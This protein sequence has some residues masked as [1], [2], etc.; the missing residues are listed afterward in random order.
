MRLSVP[1]KVTAWNIE[2]MKNLVVGSVILA[3]QVML[4]PGRALE[5]GTAVGDQ[6]SAS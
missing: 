4:Q 1:E 2:E 3:L 6:S 5:N